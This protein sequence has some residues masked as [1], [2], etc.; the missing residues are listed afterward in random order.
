MDG[1]GQVTFLDRLKTVFTMLP[2][3]EFAIV[4][5]VSDLLTPCSVLYDLQAR[6]CSIYE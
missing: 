1:Y 4:C 5:A 2:L 6:R 3:R